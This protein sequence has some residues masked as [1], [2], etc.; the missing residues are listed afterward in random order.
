MD[1]V[2][3]AA[4]ALVGLQPAFHVAINCS[5]ADLESKEFAAMV[6]DLIRAPGLGPRNI[7]IE[8]TERRLFNTELV[9]SNVAPRAGCSPGR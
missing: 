1:T 6:A 8:A 5:A 2:E 3:R 4:P 9:R 7:V